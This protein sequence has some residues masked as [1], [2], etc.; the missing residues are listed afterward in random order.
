MASA[1]I[2]WKRKMEMVSGN[3]V[4]TG[5]GA[6]HLLSGQDGTFIRKFGKDIGNRLNIFGGGVFGFS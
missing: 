6:V 1:I 3:L 4:I 5:G 2:N